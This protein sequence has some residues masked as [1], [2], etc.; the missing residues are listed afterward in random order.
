MVFGK[1]DWDRAQS[2]PPGAVVRGALH[3]WSESGIGSAR[4]FDRRDTAAF[5]VQAK[6]RATPSRCSA[7]WSELAAAYAAMSGVPNSRILTLQLSH[8]SPDEFADA[9]ITAT[10]TLRAG[11]VV[12]LDIVA[13]TARQRRGVTREDLGRALFRA[14]LENSLVWAGRAVLSEERRAVSM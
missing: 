13:R 7:P 14:G 2:D 12:A 6:S 10:E 8:D 1:T 3:H 9:L 4:A 5:L 11:D